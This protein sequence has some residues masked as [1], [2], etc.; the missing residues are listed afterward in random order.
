M[1]VPR[2]TE[3]TYAVEWIP[4]TGAA[5]AEIVERGRE[6]LDADMVATSHYR[7]GAPNPV[8]F[9]DAKPRATATRVGGDIP[10][11]TVAFLQ[12]AP[13]VGERVK[14]TAGPFA[15][16]LTLVDGCLRVAV[17]RHDSYL[18]IWP[19]EVT[20]R[21]DGGDVRVVDATGQVVARVGEP[22]ALS[23]G[24]LNTIGTEGL[25]EAPPDRCPGPYWLTGDIL[26]QGPGTATPR[27]TATRTPA[28]AFPQFA[29]VA[30]E[31]GDLAAL[32]EGTLVLVDGCLRVAPSRG[33]SYLVIWPPEVALR[34]DG[35]DVRVV[36]TEG[37]IVARVGERIA[38]G[39]GESKSI[40]GLG[41]DPR[42][43]LREVP[44]A[45]CPGP[46]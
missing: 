28:I 36:D 29:P 9:S 4:A 18:I 10:T 7:H 37:R 33:D 14:L 13:V 32:L 3:L 39:V 35:G 17:P 2:G 27:D 11:P 40:E 22:V 15:G 24:V 30:G 45:R 20:L 34:T 5:D 38:L 8:G 46:Y 43:P 12:L 23:G 16:T 42:A 41:R 21:T 26:K 25:R 44:P 19:P 31:R 6:I 1:E